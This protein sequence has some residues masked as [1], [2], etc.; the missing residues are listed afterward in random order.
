MLMGYD[1][2]GSTIARY[3]MALGIDEPISIKT[4]NTTGYYHTDG[5]GTV[6][7]ITGST[8]AIP[9]AKLAG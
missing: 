9:T 5:L 3:T 4:Q 1:I 7:E 2:S 8:G 6:R